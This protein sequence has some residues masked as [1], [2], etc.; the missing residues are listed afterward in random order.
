MTGVVTLVVDAESERAAQIAGD[1]RSCGAEVSVASDA[2]QAWERF[3]RLRPALVVA[4]PH[5]SGKA[6]AAFV[7]RMHAE[8]MGRPPRTFLLSSVDELA[9][10]SALEVDGL[11]VPPMSRA[12]AAAL[13]AAASTQVERRSDRLLDLVPL[14]LLG[15]G[16]PFDAIDLL[17]R[18]GSVGF[19]VADL[20]VWGRVGDPVW[21]RTARELSD[22]DRA[23]LLADGQRALRAG[24][25]LLA[26]ERSLVA[27]PLGASDAPVGGMCLVS[28]RPKVFS[29]DERR[30]LWSLARRTSQEMAWLAAH[31][32]LSQQ[33][34]EL[35]S[36]A[37]RDSLLGV[38]NRVAF[39][40]ATRTEIKAARRR[41]ET[42][43]LAV[44]DLVG[45]RAIN[46]RHGH[47]I[48]DR[49]LVQV[50]TI[51]KAQLRANDSIGRIDGD[52]LGVVLVGAEIDAARMVLERVLAALAASPIELPGG[53]S[54]EVAVRT[55]LT[56][57]EASEASGEQA[58]RRARAAQARARPMSVG[59]GNLRERRGSGDDFDE[60]SGVFDLEAMGGIPPGT[61]LGGMYRILHEISRGAMGVVYRAE[62]LGLGRPVAIKVLRSDLA[63]RSDLLA[64]FRAEAA[65]L[66]SLHHPNLV[67]VHSLGSEGGEV[68]F[69]MELVEGEPLSVLMKRPSQE[70]G[71]LLSRE[72]LTRTL[73]EVAGALTVLHS[74]GMLH[75]DVKPAN[76]LLDRARDRAVLVDVGVAGRSDD[77]RDTAGTPGFSAPECFM[78]R[79]ETPA[80][81]VYGLAT[82]TY[83]LLT[84]TLPFGSGDVNTVVERQL[85]DAPVPPSE[86]QRS[87]PAAV[88]EVLAT[89]LAPVPEDRYQSAA[90]F[91]AALAAALQPAGAPIQVAARAAVA[92]FRRSLG[93][94]RRSGATSSSP[95]PPPP[96]ALSP[97]SSSAPLSPGLLDQATT[98]LVRPPPGSAPGPRAAP[99]AVEPEVTGDREERATRRN[100]TDGAGAG[101]SAGGPAG[102]TGFERVAGLGHT[103]EVGPDVVVNLFPLGAGPAASGPRCRGLLFRVA[104]KSLGQKLGPGWIHQVGARDH[105]LRDLLDPTLSPDSWQSLD[106][107]V[108]LLRLAAQALE[109]PERLAGSLGRSCMAAAFTSILGADPRS[110]TPAT[111]LAAAPAFLPRLLDAGPITGELDSGADAAHI[112]LASG[113]PDPLVCALAG[114]ALGRAAE[115]AGAR[116]VAIEHP[117]CRTHGADSCRFRISWSDAPRP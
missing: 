52:E 35:R 40:H 94:Q 63:S 71:E 86:L 17:V 61:T 10:W 60:P 105:A 80:S 72:L 11:V 23:A 65:L 46:E 113:L 73:T 21:P 26:G 114:A 2:D 28:D 81:D 36:S 57:V 79:P 30:A 49:A 25:T 58:F 75:R 64:R 77:K 117:A 98:A 68:F 93:V 1:L 56:Q 95:P 108:N 55:G 106:R 89:A 96:P 103:A 84:G 6:G 78:A 88:D 47:D 43:A 104:S 3:G 24:T 67:Q 66:A 99:V 85:S 44:V 48:G 116:A 50:A 115:L 39:E 91:A 109:H 37:M 90:G 38:L 76:I 74:A 100:R 42:L 9:R 59:T 69:V 51:L 22:D 29:S 54:L 20:V 34:E 112:D 101:R 33:A 70:D 110:L 82:T 12:I 83:A 15:G 31:R 53:G 97:L 32:R 102:R 18:R 45:L 27:A 8:Y 92:R 62:D 41:R 5:V 111:V 13:T 87:L 7:R 14:S 16:D 4:A 19:G 107:L